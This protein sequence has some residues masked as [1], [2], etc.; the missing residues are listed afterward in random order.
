MNA[1][2]TITSRDSHD[3]RHIAA[4]RHARSG[5][6]RWKKD[7]TKPAPASATMSTLAT[8]KKRPS[9]GTAIAPLRAAS[10]AA[11]TARNKPCPAPVSVVSRMTD[12]A[13]FIGARTATCAAAGARHAA[14]SPRSGVVEEGLLHAWLGQLAVF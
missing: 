10:S 3:V 4:A 12:H 7:A 1:G 2:S 11:Y 13:G 14:R 9:G 8:A 6:P 5:R